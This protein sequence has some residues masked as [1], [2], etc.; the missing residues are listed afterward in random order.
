M[1]GVFDVIAY[2]FSGVGFGLAVGFVLGFVA[3]RRRRGDYVTGAK[4][5]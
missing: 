4:E 1:F 3:D 5:D 2:W